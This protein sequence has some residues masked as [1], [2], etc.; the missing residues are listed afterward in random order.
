M[1]VCMC[2]HVCACMCVREARKREIMRGVVCACLCEWVSLR[3][4]FC[5]LT[6]TIIH[7]VG[8]VTLL[9]FS[10]IQIIR[11]MNILKLS[12]HLVSQSVCG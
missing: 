4:Y 3:V 6:S 10:S 11:I 2:V 1:C 9:L 12:I 8:Q 7:L 5:V